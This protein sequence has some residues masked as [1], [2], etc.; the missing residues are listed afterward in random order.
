MIPLCEIFLKKKCKNLGPPVM[1]KQRR[2]GQHWF[3]LWTLDRPLDMHRDTRPVLQRASQGINLIKNGSVTCPFGW[4]QKWTSLL[5]WGPHGDHKGVGTS[6][7]CGCYDLIANLGLIF[8]MIRC[9]LAQRVCKDTWR[10]E[11][12]A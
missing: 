9:C 12:W 2:I 5:G 11:E 4:D 10:V 7:W 1:K 3:G 6:C 8:D